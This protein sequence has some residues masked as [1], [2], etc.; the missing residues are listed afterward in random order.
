MLP[1][2]IVFRSPVMVS[3]IRE[4][5][6]PI[7]QTNSLVLIVGK[8][9]VGKEVIARG[10]HA[11][12]ERRTQPF[13]AINLSGI[14]DALASTTLFGS[15]K[16]SY[17]GS[18]QDVKG[19]FEAAEGGTIFL[20]EIGSASKEIQ[21]KLLRVIQENEITPVGETKPRKINVRIIAGTNVNLLKLV[22]EGKFAEDLLQRLWVFPVV[23]PPLA[24]RREDI[25]VIAQQILD[26]IKAETGKNIL[27]FTP[28]AIARLEK[29]D[30]PGNVRELSNIVQRTA[31]FVQPGTYI[32]AGDIDFSSP[33]DVFK[34]FDQSACLAKSCEIPP[35][36]EGVPL[37]TQG[38]VTLS[39]SLENNNSYVGVVTDSQWPSGLTTDLA[40][41]KKAAIL[42]AF[43]PAHITQRGPTFGKSNLNYAQG[44][45]KIT[46]LSSVINDY[47]DS[48]FYK[49]YLD[50][51]DQYKNSKNK[52]DTFTL[53]EIQNLFLP[54][55][56]EYQLLSLQLPTL[57]ID[58]LHAEAIKH[59]FMTMPKLFVDDFIPS[60]NPWG[61]NFE[62]IGRALGV[63]A[64]QASV[65][66]LLQK[67]HLDLKTL[68]DE[69][70]AR[71]Q[72]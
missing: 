15:K 39:G 34:S 19:I 72:N 28:S 66:V 44:L 67:H 57:D 25:G 4:K 10:V 5:L 42:Q 63:P 1:R 71:G 2:G 40:T 27:G 14:D 45:L 68:L 59:V 47:S 18:V 52:N 51:I 55:S 54:D 33:A 12:S 32:Q 3:M 11:F 24:L 41:L 21:S 22:Q 30:Y 48:A 58:K 17:T 8:T 37:P 62:D 46:S 36:V 6:L 49:A 16:G 64:K 13:Y 23:I 26:S 70:R 50:I 29:Y 38:L 61:V 43:A 20:D 56:V 65:I 69:R 7:A 35:P 53:N 31:L 60:V 9:G